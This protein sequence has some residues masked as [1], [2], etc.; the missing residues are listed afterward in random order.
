[1]NYLITPPNTHYD[2]GLGV[3]ACNFSQA[4]DTLRRAGNAMDGVLPLCYLQRHAVELFLKSL[5]VILH[6]KYEIAYGEGFS[7][8]KPAAKVGEKWIALSSTH[9]LS[10][11]FSYFR[12]VLAATISQLPSKADWTIAPDVERKI[13]LVSGSDPKSTYF[14]YPE[15]AT[16]AHDARKSSIQ[17]ERLNSIFE[18][19]AD[20]KVPVKCTLMLDENDEIVE[21]YNF[22]SS[23]I[24]KVLESLEYLSGYFYNLHAAFRYEITNGL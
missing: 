3:T 16:S 11:L 7:A 13:Q 4:A 15:S 1:M 17:P 8:Q 14:R 12:S 24:P 23:P 2:G 10:D 19:M 9:N 18:K 22:N 6:K 21:A 5:I 20:S